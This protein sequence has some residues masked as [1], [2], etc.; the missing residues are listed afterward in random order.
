MEEE[1]TFQEKLNDHVDPKLKI[2]FFIYIIISV[3]LIGFL[4]FR[5]ISDRIWPIF[6]I[7]G[8]VGGAVI[9]VLITRILNISWDHNSQKV[10]SRLDAYG[11]M[12]LILYIVFEINREKVVGYFVHGSLVFIVSFSV[13][14]GIM[15]GRVIGMRGKILQVIE[16]NV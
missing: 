8:F 3:A 14:A 12:V 2:R 9:G 11:I 16:E 6:P 7:I 1:Q 13:L 5:M 15:I 10:I 4:V